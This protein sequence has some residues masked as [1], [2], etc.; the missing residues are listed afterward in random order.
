VVAR[1]GDDTDAFLLEQYLSVYIC[2]FVL[3]QLIMRG[4]RFSLSAERDVLDWSTGG[5]RKFLG[6]LI[7]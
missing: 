7:Q 1:F 3:A 2:F 5:V 6:L 4:G